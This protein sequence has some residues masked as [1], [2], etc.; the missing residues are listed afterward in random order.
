MMNKE[1]FIEKQE[2]ILRRKAEKEG[3]TQNPNFNFSEYMDQA[4][5]EYSEIIESWCDGC[6]MMNYISV[7]D[8]WGQCLCS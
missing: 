7:D 6:Q 4:Y 3:L 5:E 8:P 1:E 2:H